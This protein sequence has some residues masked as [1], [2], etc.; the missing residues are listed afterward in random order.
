MTDATH[1]P[2]AGSNALTRSWGWIRTL[3]ARYLIAFLI[4]LV[5]VAAQL[6]YHMFGSYDRLL[7]ALAVCMATEAILSW[8]DRGRVVNLLS[9]YISGAVRTLP[10]LRPT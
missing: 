8:F 6:R 3:D 10:L 7:L 1:A 4:T 9:A 5:L 2:T